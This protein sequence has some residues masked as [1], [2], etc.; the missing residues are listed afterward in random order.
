MTESGDAVELVDVSAD[1]PGL[2]FKPG[3]KKWKLA[4]KDNKFFS[5]WEEV[6]ENHKSLMRPF[7][8]PPEEDKIN[9][10]RFGKK[11]LHIV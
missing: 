11:T 6:P 5:S 4:A 7:M 9:L 8:F 3:L 2:K 10:E 1:L